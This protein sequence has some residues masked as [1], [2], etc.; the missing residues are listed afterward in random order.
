VAV[1]LTLLPIRGWSKVRGV[2][3]DERRDGRE[4]RVYA[5]VDQGHRKRGAA[6]PDRSRGTRRKAEKTETRAQAQVMDGRHRGA[7]AKTLAER[8]DLYLDWRSLDDRP[9]I[10]PVSI[11]SWRRQL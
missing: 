6:T 7:P 9:G 2:A 4:I 5:D 11:S 3:I 8:A 1:R 10:W